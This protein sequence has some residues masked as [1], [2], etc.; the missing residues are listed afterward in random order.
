MQHPSPLAA[1]LKS[2]P[3]QHLSTT[4]TKAGIQKKKKHEKLNNTWIT[5]CNGYDPLQ[6]TGHAILSYDVSLKGGKKT[7]SNQES[8]AWP[9]HGGSSQGKKQV[10][11]VAA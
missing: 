6:L 4:I 3:Q 11:W 9:Q 8:P 5:Y 2:R 1:E 10:S 7:P